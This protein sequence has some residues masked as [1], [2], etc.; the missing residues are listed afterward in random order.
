MPSASQNILIVDW[1]LADEGYA[2]DTSD[3]TCWQ[4]EISHPLNM[5]ERL[6]RFLD[7]F[8]QI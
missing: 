6:Q 2:P 8:V 4:I 5:G 7:D 3:R 1:W